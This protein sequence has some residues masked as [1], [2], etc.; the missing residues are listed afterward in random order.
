MSDAII[1]RGLRAEARIGV[2]PEERAEP[3]FLRI[4]LELERD[5][6]R[7]SASDDLADT[8]DYSAVTRRVVEIA[9]QNEVALLERLGELIAQDLL[10]DDNLERVTVVLG[11]ERPPIPEEVEAV[12]VRLVRQR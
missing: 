6:S 4:D 8:V 7:A 12:Q 10:S 5:L 2:T 9:G 1:F 3:Q 11:K